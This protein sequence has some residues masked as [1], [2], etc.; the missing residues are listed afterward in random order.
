[1]Y[2]VAKDHSLLFY[3]YMPTILEEENKNKYM[4]AYCASLVA[5]G[6]FWEVRLFLL[7][8]GHTHED[9]DQR[10]NIIFGVFKRQDID[11][12]KE[13]LAFIKRGASYTEAFTSASLMEHIWDW[14]G[15]ITVHL[16]SGSDA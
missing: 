2:K 11:S 7:I 5:F 14:K 4:F 3:E 8:V 10:F 12:V 13:M 9:I 15:Y 6:Y 16:H 1:M